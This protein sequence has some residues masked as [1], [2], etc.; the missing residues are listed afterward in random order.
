MG[1]QQAQLLARGAVES[2]LVATG[3]ALGEPGEVS[4]KAVVH[5]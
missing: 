2:V 3:L 5:V 4:E 1:V